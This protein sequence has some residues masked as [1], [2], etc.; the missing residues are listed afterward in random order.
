MFR[1][2]EL[3]AQKS[4][5][6]ILVGPSWL[7]EQAAAGLR[8]KHVLEL[9]KPS[10]PVGHLLRPRDVLTHHPSAK[11]VAAKL[12]CPT[13][14]CGAHQQLVDPLDARVG[15]LH[16]RDERS[17]HLEFRWS[18]GRMAPIVAAT[19]EPRIRGAIP[20][21]DFTGLH[22]NN[23]VNPGQRASK[24]FSLLVLSERPLW[25]ASL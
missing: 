1:T 6:H 13:C 3:V 2:S 9:L 11:S 23:Q 10:D 19:S 20:C 4:G 18:R 24:R 7:H 12:V 25:W 15:S 5:Q 8:C 16:P 14:D 22:T 17:S 21:V